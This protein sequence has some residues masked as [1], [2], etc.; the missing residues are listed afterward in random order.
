M[1]QPETGYIRADDV[2]DILKVSK[3]RAYKVIKELNKELAGK[4]FYTISGRI[5]K[6]YLFE[7]MNIL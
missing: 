6:A 3:G 7:R 2:K 1:K 4:G 5:S